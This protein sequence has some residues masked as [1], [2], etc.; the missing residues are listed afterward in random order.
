MGSPVSSEVGA[1]LLVIVLPLFVVWVLAV[2]DIVG[3]PRMSRR[4]KWVWV[5]MCSLVWPVLV[6]YFLTRPVQ[7]RLER[8]ESRAYPHA[9]LVDAALAHEEGR[10]D[11]VRLAAVVRELRARQVRRAG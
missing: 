9:Q 11:D 5:L 8:A 1:Y 3:Q 2:V 4:A 10:I 6:V 7:G